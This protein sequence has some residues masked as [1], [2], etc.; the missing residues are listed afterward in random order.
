M[1]SLA[2]ALQGFFTN[3]TLWNHNT[4]ERSHYEAALDAARILSRAAYPPSGSTSRA[5]LLKECTGTVDLTNTEQA[6]VLRIIQHLQS[7]VYDATDEAVNG[8]GGRSLPK[9]LQDEV[10]AVVKRLQ[11]KKQAIEYRVLVGF[12][13]DDETS[14]P[15][16][17]TQALNCEKQDSE[18]Q[19]AVPNSEPEPLELGVASHKHIRSISLS[20]ISGIATL[21]CS[22][23]A[24][25]ASACFYRSRNMLRSLTITSLAY[26]LLPDT[27]NLN[28]AHA[29][30]VM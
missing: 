30:I 3:T 22:L 5:I 13:R 23:M 29:S 27:F 14:T 20:S 21:Q 26:K 28:M 2:I 11:N 17:Y 8:L 7:N 10:D 1:S 6:D 15:S 19:L 12:M 25:Q 4:I 18:A 24:L 9:D 16:I